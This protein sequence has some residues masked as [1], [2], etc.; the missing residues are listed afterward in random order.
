M[1]DTLGITNTWTATIGISNNIWK[2]HFKNRFLRKN[3]VIVWNAHWPSET[4]AP[5]LLVYKWRQTALGYEQKKTKWGNIHFI[6]KF[7]LGLCYVIKHRGAQINICGRVFADIKIYAKAKLDLK[8]NWKNPFCYIHVVSRSN[9][10]HS[11]KFCQL[12]SF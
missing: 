10:I 8:K 5:F 11:T 7:D 1:C 4:G 2:M 3:Y 9:Y 12:E 6:I